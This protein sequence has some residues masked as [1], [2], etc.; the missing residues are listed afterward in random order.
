MRSY[1]TYKSILQFYRKSIPLEV[2]I[3]FR[4]PM[5]LKIKFSVLKFLFLFFRE[6]I[7]N[8]EKSSC[9]AA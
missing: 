4:L 2:S 1:L 3:H 6:Y 8:T 7:D 5:V 9:V